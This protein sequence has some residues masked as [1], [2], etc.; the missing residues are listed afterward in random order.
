MLETKI[1]KKVI[2]WLLSIGCKVI[3]LKSATRKGNADLVI[4]YM[5]L[6]VEF[7]MKQPG[8]YATKLQKIKGTETTEASG[9]WFEIHSLEEAQDAIRSLQNVISKDR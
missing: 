6:Y 9:Y 2:E 3:N 4:C 8:C 5:G 7:E 1:Q